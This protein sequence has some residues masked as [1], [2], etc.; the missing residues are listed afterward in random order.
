MK[1][2]AI[3]PVSK[4]RA[5]KLRERK[6]LIAAM[7]ENGPVLCQFWSHFG[8]GRDP[9]HRAD[10]LHEPGKRSQGADPSD[11]GSVIPLCR[12]HHDWVHR[13]PLDAAQMGLLDSRWVSDHSVEAT[14]MGLVAARRARDGVEGG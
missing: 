8:D 1:R 4:R 12:E 7:E 14:A 9:V 5:A 11:A 10:D 2:S 3:K 6:T 13:H